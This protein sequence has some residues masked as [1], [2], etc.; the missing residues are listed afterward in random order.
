MTAPA[1]LARIRR[2]L[3]SAR[4]PD[5]GAELLAALGELATAART[6]TSSAALRLLGE[7]PRALLELDRAVRADG[8]RQVADPGPEQLPT[9]PAALALALCDRNGRLRERAV[10]EA[11]GRLT[12]RSPAFELAA[13]LVIRTG[14]WAAPVRR[15]ARAA[16][17][18][19][20]DEHPAELL[21][22]VVR[23]VVLTD[24]RDRGAFAHRQTAAT[25]AHLPVTPQLD[26][27]VPALLTAPDLRV[28]RFALQARLSGP[29]RLPLSTLTDLAERDHDGR[30][31]SIA[32]E[33]AVREAL[34]TNRPDL[35]RRLTTSRHAEVRALAL[36]A[37]VRS[38][39]PDEAAER[40]TDPSGQVRAL[41]RDAVRRAGGD[42]LAHYREAVRADEPSPG[43]IAGLTET[44]HRADTALLLPLLSHPRPRVRAAAVRGLRGL[45]PVP[46]ETLLPLLRDPSPKVVRETAGTLRSRAAH[47]PSDLAA[48]LLAEHDRPAVRRAGYLLLH[49][50]DPVAHLARVL[51]LTTDPD[52]R[53]ASWAATSAAHRARAL[54]TSGRHTLRPAN[55]EERAALV[56][57]AESAASALPP[58]TRQLLRAALDPT[59]G[60]PVG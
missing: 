52:P 38:G 4:T 17:A 50:P 32:A 45:G 8:T 5:S 59:A 10:H 13:L 2:V 26:R 48:D 36:T 51:R 39:R 25:L 47:L 34:W 43:A 19:A 28:R 46:A 3:A 1:P 16:L 9:D 44:G 6:A 42:A 7:H 58:A 37:L 21:P 33:A 23:T 35:L 24:R 31:R 54:F 53:L 41:A 15:A 12:G 20:L 29:Q 49:E 60:E 40:L 18:L 30:L 11:A 22:V 14:D 55:P 27:V 57:L 56:P